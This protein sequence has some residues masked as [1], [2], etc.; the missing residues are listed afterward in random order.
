MTLLTRT[1]LVEKPLGRETHG[2]YIGLACPSHLGGH[3]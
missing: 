2:E 1:E 3:K